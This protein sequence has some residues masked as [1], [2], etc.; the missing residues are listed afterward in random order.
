MQCERPNAKA[1]GAFNEAFAYGFFKTRKDLS[2]ANKEANQHLK[3]MAEQKAKDEEAR[4]ASDA[5]WAKNKAKAYE[6]EITRVQKLLKDKVQ[7]YADGYLK[8]ELR[9]LKSDYNWIKKQY[10]V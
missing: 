3:N 1:L 5:I 4:K 8:K 7:Y 6:D 9:R 2:N 10:G